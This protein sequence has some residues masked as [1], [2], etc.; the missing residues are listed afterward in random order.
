MNKSTRTLLIIFA[1]LAVIYFLF[2]RSKERVSTDKI[3]AKLFVADSSKIDKIEL[4][5]KTDAVTLE[6]LN[7]V[8]RITKP[9][10]YP[11]DTNAVYPMLGNLKNFR[12]EDEASRNPA[13][14]NEYLDTAYNTQVITYQEGKMLGTFILGKTASSFDVSYIKKPDEE[15]ILR[16]SSISSANFNKPVKD[17]RNKLIASIPSKLS[18]KITFKSTDTNNVDF[19]AVKDSTGKWWV[20]SDS[21]TSTNM[22]GFLNMFDNWNTEDFKDTTMTIFPAPTYTLSFYGPF[23]PSPMTI[24]LYHEPNSSPN[25]F[26]V[27]VTGVQQLFRFFDGMASQVMKKKKDFVP[28]PPKMETPKKETKK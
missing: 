25:A 17:F 12:I 28:E 16:A 8:W 7:G 9:I 22:D 14:F 6:K 5:R 27:Q 1:L 18:N 13:K 11:A 15:R 19:T 10:D 26:I 2:F 23:N 3:D 21:V 24:N 4:I 20:A